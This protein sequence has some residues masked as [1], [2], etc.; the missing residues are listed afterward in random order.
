MEPDKPLNRALSKPR[1]RE[2]A[3]L[4]RDGARQIVAPQIEVLKVE[5]IA[6]LGRE[7]PRQ[8]VARQVEVGD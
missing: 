7:L 3:D 8:T 6:D 5:E 1:I 4:R 2:L